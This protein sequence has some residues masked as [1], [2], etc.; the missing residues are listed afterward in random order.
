M[1]INAVAQTLAGHLLLRVW[2]MWWRRKP[3]S[4]MWM[5]RLVNSSSE[6]STFISLPTGLSSRCWNSCGAT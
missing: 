4:A 2:M 3:A 1:T 5:G 6:A